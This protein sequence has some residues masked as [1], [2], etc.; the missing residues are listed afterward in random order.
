MG[1]YVKMM[2]MNS[3]SEA[4]QYIKY[5]QSIARLIEAQTHRSKKEIQGVLDKAFEQHRRLCGV[6]EEVHDQLAAAGRYD[7]MND[8]KAFADIIN[9]RLEEEGW[10][11]VF[12]EDDFPES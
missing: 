12:E 1:Q 6:A 7:V 3:R 2:Y 8:K 5:E 4:T 9:K 10:F 11:D